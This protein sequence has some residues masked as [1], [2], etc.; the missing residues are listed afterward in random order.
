MHMIRLRREFGSILIDISITEELGSGSDV[1]GRARWWIRVLGECKIEFED[2]AEIWV[3]SKMKVKCQILAPDLRLALVVRD[4]SI[5]E[6]VRFW[7]ELTGECMIEFEDKAEIWVTSKMKV[8]CQ[9][10][11]PG[12]GIALVVRK[13]KFRIKLKCQ[14]LAPGLGLALVGECAI[15]FQDYSEARVISMMTVEFQA[16]VLR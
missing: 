9:I 10:L 6:R 3:T 11:A 1:K 16:T 13:D 15:Q 2:K 7:S 14:I 12:P 4:I 8:K 5:T